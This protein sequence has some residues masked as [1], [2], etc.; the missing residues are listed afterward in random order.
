MLGRLKMSIS[1]CI[2]AYKEMAPR[3]FS[4]RLRHRKPVKILS[5]AAGVTWFK[6]EDLEKAM[7]DLLVELDAKGKLTLKEGVDPKGLLLREADDP[8][9]RV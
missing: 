9:C 5:G 4:E 3:V 2:V 6:G 7:Q 8:A 1:E